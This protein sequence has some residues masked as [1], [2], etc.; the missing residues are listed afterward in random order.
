MNIQDILVAQRKAIEIQRSI[1]YQ[2]FQLAVL[3]RGNLRNISRNNAYS[4]HQLLASLKA[5]L[6]QYN[7]KSR[8]WKN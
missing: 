5:E 3:L 6:S 4:E 8:K 1:E 2:S 7:A